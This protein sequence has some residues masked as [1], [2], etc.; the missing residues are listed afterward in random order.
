VTTV[1]IRTKLILYTLV[2]AGLAS[3]GVTYYAYDQQKKAVY[4]QLEERG[5]AFGENLSRTLAD[6]IYM[7]QIDEVL[8]L[9]RSVRQDPEISAA[10]ALDE[11][12]SLLSDG[13]KRNLH[14]GEKLQSPYVQEALATQRS[15]I[16][17]LAAAY[18][19]VEPVRLPNGNTIGYAYI[20]LSLAQRS[21]ALS[22]IFQRTLGLSVLYLVSAAV[23]AYF[24][25][26]S[27]STP[28]LNLVK[29]TQVVEKGNFEIRIGSKRRDELGTLA[30]GFNTMTSGL[31]E[32]ERERDIFGR[33][34][35]PEVRE[36]LLQGKL[37]LGGDL[38]RVAVL[39]SDIRGFSST[40]ER[41]DAEEVV[42]F[43][44][45]YLTEMTEA[46]RQWGGYLNNFLGDAILAVF[47]APVDQPDKEWRA[48]AAAMTMRERLAQ[49]NRR[50][51]E[52]GDPPIESGTGICTGDVVAGLIGSLE[53]LQYTVIGDAVNV[54]ER[55]EE[56]TRENPSYPVL[57]NGLTAQAL[58][59]R[60]DVQLQNL[61]S[62]RLRG[63]SQ[64]VD[65]YAVIG[66]H[67]FH[68]SSP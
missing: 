2:I 43:L 61:G 23:L 10:Y 50:R 65:V 34:V 14:R 24:V 60:P 49:L 29:A 28:I 45:E 17:R 40:S 42:A 11:K 66:L 32:R 6:P 18:V 7:L 22:D 5:K 3:S 12:G 63:R 15:I 64:P 52:R 13:T 47:G 26:Y 1:G 67:P 41:L 55:L 31:H 59:A 37:E 53:R 35:S 27:F 38:R 25:A 33:A 39:F 62:V 4:R 9:L 16:Q 46:I 8:Y 48:V 56:L 21:R 19:I 30:R 44:N 57:V 54:A 58:T 36:R 68:Q 20:E 51:G